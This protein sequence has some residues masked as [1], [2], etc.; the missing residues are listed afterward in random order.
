[1]IDRPSRDWIL[2]ASELGDLLH[3]CKNLAEAFADRLWIAKMICRISE[4]MIV[5]K[6][7]NSSYVKPLNTTRIS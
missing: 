6:E 3:P 2:I 4:A 1:M 7:F 5:C